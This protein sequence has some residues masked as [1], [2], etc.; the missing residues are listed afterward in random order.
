MDKKLNFLNFDLS[1]GIKPFQNIR[2]K[3]EEIKMKNIEAEA[4]VSQFADEI[5]Q[6]ELPKEVQNF[7]VHQNGNYSNLKKFLISGLLSNLIL[8]SFKIKMKESEQKHPEE[9]SLYEDS[10]DMLS[11]PWNDDEEVGNYFAKIKEFL[12][13]NIQIGWRVTPKKVNVWL[14]LV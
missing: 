7:F 13:N 11:I 6:Q 8:W 10:I 9:I 12:P 3:E 14:V 1:K 2:Q 4:V 5:L